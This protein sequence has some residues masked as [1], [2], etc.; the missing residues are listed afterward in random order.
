MKTLVAFALGALFLISCGGEQTDQPV[1]ADNPNVAFQN[2][3]PAVNT[4][5]MFA[6]ITTS[7]G[8]IKIA[9][10]YEK[11][12]LTVANFVGLAEGTFTNNAKP[13]GEP[14]Y[15]G[16]IFHRVISVANGDPQDFMV[17]GGDPQGTGAGGP[18][19]SFRDEFHPQLRHDRPGILSMANSGPST[20]GS[21]FFITIKATP[22]LDNKHSIFGH[23]VS[24]QAIVNQMKQGE[25]MQSVRIVRQGPR[26]E[27]FDA[28]A[29]F[30][31]LV[32]Q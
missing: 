19:Y 30:A 5:S 7:R 23:V 32:N 26:A 22:W 12:P 15:D 16:M 4:D 28:A 17:Q 21:Q 8:R 31:A 2:E 3:N 27:N 29:V 18:G 14:Y 20:N 24:G 1:A 11:A 9:L 13:A 10:E 25:V 6:I